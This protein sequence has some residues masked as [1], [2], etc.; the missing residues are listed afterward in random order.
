MKACI[1]NGVLNLDGMSWDV[2]EHAMNTHQPVNSSGFNQWI[3][4]TV[5]CARLL[6]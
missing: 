3:S 5:E 1:T 6:S 2:H 4:T